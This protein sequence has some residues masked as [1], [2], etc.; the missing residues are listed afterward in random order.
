MKFENLKKEVK[1]FWE[2]EPCGSRCS[3]EELN[4]SRSG[5]LELFKIGKG[6]YVLEIGVGIGLDFL[7]WVKNGAFATGVDLTENAI[8]TTRKR[9][10]ENNLSLDKINLHTADAENL[11]FNDDTFDIVYSCGVLHHTPNTNKAFQEA[12]RVLKKGE[13][14]YGMVYNTYS[15]V[16]LML[17]IRYS[18]L[19]G[20]IFQSPKKAVFLHLESPGTKVYSKSEFR[21][22]LEKIGFNDISLE[23]ELCDADLLKNKPSDKYNSMVYKLIW[24][25]YPRWLVKILGPKFGL[26]LNI[27]AKK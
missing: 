8:E 15:W 4:I 18:L 6:K 9:I 17:W 13:K 25:I 26:F 14:F 3:Q 21:K 1:N 20:K 12:Y 5:H 23:A 27:T 24:K 7:E 19:T 2:K 16:V 10:S 11:P 22:M